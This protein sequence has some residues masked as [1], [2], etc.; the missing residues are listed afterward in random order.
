MVCRPTPFSLPASAYT[1]KHGRFSHCRNRAPL[2]AEQL[3]FVT[4]QPTIV[5]SRWPTALIGVAHPRC[6]AYS[7]ERR[8]ARSSGPTSLLAR[9]PM[10]GARLSTGWQLGH[11]GVRPPKAALEGGVE[12]ARG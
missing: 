1:Q 3:A 8:Q 5:E 11:E 4:H 7:D 6:W 12:G 2:R 9:A 10:A